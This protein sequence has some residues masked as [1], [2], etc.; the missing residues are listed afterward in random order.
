[1]DLCRP[2]GLVPIFHCQTFLICHPEY[3]GLVSILS[4]LVFILCFLL[5]VFI[6]F[7]VSF[8]FVL[9]SCSLRRKYDGM[10]FLSS[11]ATLSGGTTRF[12]SFV[13]ISSV[14]FLLFILYLFAFSL[15]SMCK[16]V[17]MESSFRL[18][19]QWVL[20]LSPIDNLIEVRCFLSFVCFLSFCLFL[21]VVICE[22]SRCIPRK[23]ETNRF[24]RILRIFF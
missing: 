9:F 15:L 18:R 10:L 8:A 20:L 2:F 7:S 17:M 3:I 23:D 16:R 21:R 11:T 12:Y 22:V 13:V 14:C 4:L 24:S 19:P 5:L 6:F 1:M